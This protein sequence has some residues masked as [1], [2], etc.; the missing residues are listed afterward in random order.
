LRRFIALPYRLHRNDSTWVPPL[1]AEVARALDR[2]RNPFFEHGEAEYF[3]AT[4]GDW[5][6]GR[7]A[8]IANHAHTAFHGDRV[9]FFGFFEVEPDPEAARALLDTA[10]AWCRDRGFDTLRGPTSF[11]TNDECGLLVEGF[12]TPNTILMPHNP[13]W[14]ATLVEEAGFT[15]AKDL[16]VYQ[17]GSLTERSPPPERLTR[18]AAVLRQRLGLTLRPIH[19]H[20]FD[21][22][23]ELVKHL[24]HRCWE[25]NWG[26]VPLTDREMEAL[27]RA[28]KPIVYPELAPIV[29]R[30]G[31]PI[32][33]GLALP[34][35]NEALRGNRSGRT[36]PAV[37]KLLWWLKRRRFRRLRIL[38]LGVVPE[39]RGRGIDGLLYHH[40]WTTA[41]E[42]YGM[43]WGEAGWILEDNA[44]ML[45][46]LEKMT[47]QRYKTY[48]LYERPL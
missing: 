36:V 25:R 37:L 17:G 48:R 12:H 11:S 35:L 14:Y 39:Y 19:L 33:F 4:R 13:P 20:D 30:A 3:L 21:A 2:T 27:A 9:G 44:P 18:A 46:A 45:Q 32:A 40:I 34:D 31:A 26:F 1:R 29:E 24:Y 47:F 28:F 7:I 5:V 15:K 23:V 43:T 10:A 38:L 42:R 8:A 6:V 22:E 16:L 41:Q